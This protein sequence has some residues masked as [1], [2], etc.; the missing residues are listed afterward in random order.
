MDYKIKIEVFQYLGSILIKM[1]KCKSYISV[2]KI[3]LNQFQ[4]SN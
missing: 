1:Q 3:L 2:V 4:H